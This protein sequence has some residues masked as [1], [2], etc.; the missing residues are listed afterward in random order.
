LPGVTKKIGEVI[1]GNGGQSD[2]DPRVVNVVVGDVKSGGVCLQTQGSVSFF[3][4]DHD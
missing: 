1:R 4:P 3:D 2:E